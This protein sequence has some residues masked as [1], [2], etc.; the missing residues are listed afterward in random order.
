MCERCQ[1]WAQ[2]I[3]APDK[4]HIREE[5]GISRYGLNDDVMGAESS[6]QVFGCSLAS[7]VLQ[8]QALSDEETNPR[9]ARHSYCWLIMQE[10]FTNFVL[11]CIS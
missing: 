1:F 4:L 9:A 7:Y 10:A 6:L 8:F 11:I 2:A 5:F 3:R